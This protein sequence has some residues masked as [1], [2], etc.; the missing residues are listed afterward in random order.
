[1]VVMRDGIKQKAE[2]A[3]RLV[4]EYKQRLTQV[5][6]EEGE[7]IREEAEEEAVD[8]ISRAHVP[9]GR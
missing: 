5:I 7:Q 6:E 1:M 3:A 9:A 8:I 4:D 2:E